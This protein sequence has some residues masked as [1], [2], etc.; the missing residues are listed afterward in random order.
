MTTEEQTSSAP[1]DRHGLILEYLRTAPG[2]IA[3]LS[4][5]LVAVTGLVVALAAR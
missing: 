3:S 5:L 2:F 4:G 1:R